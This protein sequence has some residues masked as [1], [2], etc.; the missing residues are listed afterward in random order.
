MGTD[1][2]TIDYIAELQKLRAAKKEEVRAAIDREKAI[3]D[4]P[5]STYMERI[6]AYLVVRGLDGQY[7][8]IVDL[9]THEAKQAGKKEGE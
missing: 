8:G 6:N 2:K 5:N 9:I 7:D 3:R 1:D 4:D